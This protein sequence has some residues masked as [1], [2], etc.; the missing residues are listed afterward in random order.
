MHTQLELEGRRAEVRHNIEVARAKARERVMED[1]KQRRAA[2]DRA[3]SSRLEE[4][5]MR[6]IDPVW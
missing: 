6:V 3:Y 5:K 2:A 1:E 4:D